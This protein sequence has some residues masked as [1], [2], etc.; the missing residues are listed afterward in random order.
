M[1]FSLS[2][3]LLLYG[4]MLVG[5]SLVAHRIAPDFAG[6]TLTIGVAGGVFTML[7]GVLGLRGFRQR[8]WPIVTLTIVAVLLLV[9]AVKAWLALRAGGEALKPVAVILSVLVMFAIGQLMNLAQSGRNLRI[10]FGDDTDNTT[11]GEGR[12]QQ[13]P[14]PPLD[15]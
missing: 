15:E 14:P 12:R 4:L 7:W 3:D 2:L 9:Q 1:N 8:A 11:N 13:R 5:L 10:K 6:T